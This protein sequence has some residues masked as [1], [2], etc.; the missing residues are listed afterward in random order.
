MIETIPNP[1]Q[2]Q[3]VKQDI[4]NKVNEIMRTPLRIHGLDTAMRD[5]IKRAAEWGMSEGFR[6]GWKVY[7]VTK[8]DER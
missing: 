2:D 5:A 6:M 3:G 4:E 1:L 7:E 8:G